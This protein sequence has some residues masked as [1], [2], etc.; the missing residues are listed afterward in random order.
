[1]PYHK[2]LVFLIALALA[3]SAVPAQAEDDSGLSYPAKI[4]GKLGIGMINAVTGLVEI[5]KSVMIVSEQE[6]PG[7][8]VTLGLVK[9]LTNALGRSFLGML[10]VISFPIPTKPLVNPPVVFQDFDKE[11][12]YGTGWE[13][14]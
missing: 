10:D 11:T 9:G 2:Q 5:P 1:M 14:Y 3:L 4:G 8:G 6:N 13:N 12:T 7:L